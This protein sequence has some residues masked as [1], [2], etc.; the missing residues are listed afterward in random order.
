VSNAN[1]PGVVD[2]T[3]VTKGSG[4][5]GI[6]TVYQVGNAGVLPTGDTAT[7]AK[8]PITIPAGLSHALASGVSSTGAATPR[9]MADAAATISRIQSTALT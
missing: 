8:V 1:T 4:S 5:N 7:L 6:N 9:H 2:P 3:N